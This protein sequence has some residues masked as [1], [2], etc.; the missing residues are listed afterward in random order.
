VTYDRIEIQYE[1]PNRPAS[2][3]AQPDILERFIDCRSIVRIKLQT[4]LQE[5]DQV[6]DLEGA[7][8]HVLNLEEMFQGVARV[9][10]GERAF[11]AQLVFQ[12]V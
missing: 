3:S 10:S 5:I 1:A 2:S 4:S 9:F 7:Q 6:R 8:L 11:E 12:I